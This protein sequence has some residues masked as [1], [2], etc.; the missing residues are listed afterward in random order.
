[1]AKRPGKR[2][3]KP[4]RLRIGGELLAAIKADNVWFA[5]SD[6]MLPNWRHWPTQ[7]AVAAMEEPVEDGRDHESP[8]QAKVLAD[9]AIGRLLLYL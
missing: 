2:S 1:V 7:A 9:T 8:R 4:Q 6:A 3:A 5:L